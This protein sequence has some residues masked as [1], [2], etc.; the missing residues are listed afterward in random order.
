MKLPHPLHELTQG[1]RYIGEDELCWVESSRVRQVP[2]AM[3]PEEHAKWVKP[4]SDL[5]IHVQSSSHPSA[6]STQQKSIR[7]IVIVRDHP[8]KKYFGAADFVVARRWAGTVVEGVAVEA[9]FDDETIDGLTSWSEGVVQKIK[10]DFYVITFPESNDLET[11][12]VS[13]LLRRGS[14]RKRRRS[15]LQRNHKCRPQCARGHT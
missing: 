15:G 3:T 13:V 4:S 12:E 1:C 14:M 5:H 11:N 7:S 10:G 8:G 6:L 2:V 9:G